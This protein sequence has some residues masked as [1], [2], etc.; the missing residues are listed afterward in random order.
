M[1]VNQKKKKKK[2]RNSNIFDCYK[3]LDTF[4]NILKI[5]KC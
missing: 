1:H 3:L 5:G 4:Y 2:E